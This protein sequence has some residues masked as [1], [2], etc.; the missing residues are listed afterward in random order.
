MYKKIL[1][2]LVSLL[3]LIVFNHVIY[4]LIHAPTHTYVDTWIFA[5]RNNLVWVFN[6]V[7][8]ALLISTPVSW[9]LTRILRG[10]YYGMLE[11]WHDRML[12]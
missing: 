11:T 5:H 1:K 6:S 2:T 3:I 9:M 10:R 4:R 7:S 12:Y 8:C